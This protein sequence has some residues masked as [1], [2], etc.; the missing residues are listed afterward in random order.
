LENEVEMR[1]E[2]DVHERK[3]DFFRNIFS[4]N[5]TATSK[6]SETLILLGSLSS[7]CVAPQDQL[8]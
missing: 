6:Y 2:I 5:Y 8:P 7:E 1:I 4:I 3:L